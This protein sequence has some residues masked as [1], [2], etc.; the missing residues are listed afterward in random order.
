MLYMLLAFSGL[1]SFS[2]DYNKFLCL[3]RVG[4]LGTGL[5]HIRG[6]HS[7]FGNPYEGVRLPRTFHDGPLSNGGTTLTWIVFWSLPFLEQKGR[8]RRGGLW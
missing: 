3:P 6:E 1:L 8:G 5:G 2:G 4:K 7:G